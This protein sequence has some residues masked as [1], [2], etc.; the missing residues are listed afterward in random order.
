[1]PSSIGDFLIELVPPQLVFT[2]VLGAQHLERCYASRLEWLSRPRSATILRLH[3]TDSKSHPAGVLP[4]YIGS[5]AKIDCRQTTLLVLREHSIT[6][7][8]KFPL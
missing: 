5:A 2:P 1:M 7:I 8:G 3:R 6:G 4:E